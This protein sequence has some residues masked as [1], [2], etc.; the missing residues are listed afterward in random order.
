MLMKKKTNYITPSGYEKLTTEHDHLL[1]TERPEILKVIQWA[2]GNGDRSENADYLYGKRRLREID[3]RMRFLKKQIDN[4]NVIN[5]EN[6]KSETVKFGATITVID[7]EE[8]E[9]VYSIVGVDEIDTSK[10]WI[11]MH[12]PIGKALMG[13]EEGDSVLIRTPKG[14]REFEIISISYQKIY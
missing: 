6:I 5:P 14:E 1:L 4:A 10:N 13:N 12:S 7:E 2:A 3:R 9:R 11:S 8:N